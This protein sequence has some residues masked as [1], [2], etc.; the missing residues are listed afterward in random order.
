MPA[1]PDP[2]VSVVDGLRSLLHRG[3]IFFLLLLWFFSFFYTGR[4]RVTGSQ[5]TVY[6]HP[7]RI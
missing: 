3:T 5:V 4:S 6:V 2:V 7:G 1:R